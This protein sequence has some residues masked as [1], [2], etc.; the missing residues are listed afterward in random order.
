MRTGEAGL[1]AFMLRHWRG[2][3]SLARSYWVNA[4]AFGAAF[5]LLCLFVGYVSTRGG[6]RYG[7]LLAHLFTFFNI[8][9]FVWS[10]VGVLRSAGKLK[11]LRTFSIGAALARLAIVAGAGLVCLGI[12]ARIHGVTEAWRMA[13]WLQESAKWKVVVLNDGQEIELRGGVSAGLSDALQSALERNPRVRLVRT[14]L[15]AGGL[16]VEAA[17]VAALI[18]SRNLDTKVSDECHS[19]CAIIFLAGRNRVVSSHASM[20]FHRFWIPGV[21]EASNELAKFRQGMLAANVEKSFIERA[22]STDPPNLYYADA[23]ELLLV[24]FATRIDD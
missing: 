13:N 8:P 9:L 14:E 2:E 10:S 5:A 16:V 23:R 6:W 21:G 22:L 7:L 24:R 1:S 4:V 17:Q 12:P 15:R 19:A 11:S 18:R 3:Y 20:G